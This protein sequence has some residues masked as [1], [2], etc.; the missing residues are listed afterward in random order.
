[1][2]DPL[3]IVSTDGH[4]G[5]PFD[6]YR[7]YIDPAYR[8]RMSRVPWNFGGGPV[9]IRLRS[10]DQCGRRVRHSRRS[11]VRVPRGARA[12]AGDR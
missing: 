5:Q 11:G 6:Q 8:E 3:V 2:D 10:P 12:S 9:S 4:I 1:M 7:D